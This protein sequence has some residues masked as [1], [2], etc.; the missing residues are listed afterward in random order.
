VVEPFAWRSAIPC[1]RSSDHHTAPAGFTDGQGQLLK[2]TLYTDEVVN[3][4]HHDETR[5]FLRRMNDWLGDKLSNALST[6]EMFYLVALLV[7]VP[8]IWQRPQGLVGWMQYMIAVFF[9][10]TALPVLGYVA[11]KSGES[12]EKVMRET[13]D[14]V[15]EELRLMREELHLAKEERHALRLIIQELRQGKPDNS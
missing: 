10:G 14:T 6:M 1:V 11:R 8:L 15:M 2:T 3:L 12:Q 9:Q 4:A 5:G 13:H 7:V